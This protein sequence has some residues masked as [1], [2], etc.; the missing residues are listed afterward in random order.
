MPESD[1][2]MLFVAQ[3]GPQGITRY[4]LGRGIKLEPDALNDLLDALVGAGLLTR[5]WHDEI[6][7][8]HARSGATSPAIAGSSC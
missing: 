3:A 2:V 6:Q 8:F 5:T 4:K 1:K 7:V